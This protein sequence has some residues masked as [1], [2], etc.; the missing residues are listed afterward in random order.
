MSKDNL[1]YGRVFLEEAIRKSSEETPN[2]IEW[3]G[4]SDCPIVN[5]LLSEIKKLRER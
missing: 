4:M 2:L 5:Y 3:C 1:E